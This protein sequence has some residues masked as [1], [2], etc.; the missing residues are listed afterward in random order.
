MVILMEIFLLFV[1]ALYNVN[2]TTITIPSFPLSY[3]TASGIT[4]QFLLQTT[5][6]NPFQVLPSGS[7][8]NNGGV[9]ASALAP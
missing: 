5:T 8:I 4:Q 3:S 2:A 6:Q 9:V 7:V 1:S